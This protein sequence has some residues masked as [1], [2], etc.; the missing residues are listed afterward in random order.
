[1]DYFYAVCKLLAGLGGFL[2]GFKLISENVEKMA[3]G[4]MRNWFNKT[5]RNKFLG[6][7][8]GMASTAMVQSSAITTVMTIGLVNAGIMSLYQ[9]TAII[10]GANIGTTI[11]AHIVA[12]Q[13]INIIDSAIAFAFIGIFMSMI[14][15]EEKVRTI[16][17]MLSGLGLVFM[18]LMFMS[19]SMS[20]FQESTTIKR[21]LTEC[22]NPFLLLLFGIVSTAIMQSSSALTS[23]IIT[24]SANNL[25]IGGGG[26]CVLYVILGS[27]IGSC[28]TALISSVGT[29]ANA[30]RVALIH[31][32]FNLIGSMI[33]MTVLL[34]WKDFMAVTFESW[35]K[36]PPMQIA[37]FHTFFNLIC[38]LMFVWFID[39]FVRIATLIIPDKKTTKKQEGL[40]TRVLKTTGVAIG[41]VIN[42]CKKMTDK[43]IDV[44]TLAFNSFIESDSTVVDEIDNKL[45]EIAFIYRD[46]TDYLIKISAENVGV[47]GEAMIS[48]LHASLSDILRIS[49]LSD[50]IV[51]YTRNEIENNLE[52][53]DTVIKE[54][55]A[56]FGKIEEL[57][58][59]CMDAFVNRNKQALEKADETENRIDEYRKTLIADHIKRLNEGKCKPQSSNVFISLVGNLERAADHLT[60]IAHA[61]DNI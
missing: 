5:S 40:D 55:K 58:L 45:H 16:G 25:I 53:S 23:I 56:M 47:K 57:H 59:E 9:A 54:L 8:I 29:N 32:L 34:L 36:K 12:L 51:K 17:M 49:E 19:Q 37:M 22:K 52:F 26:N 1:M 2:I 30:K 4:S 44:L 60:Y 42:E 14:V 41:L 33:F 43:S 48:A 50:N 27:N 15:K 20:V 10:M 7:G 46:I 13:S 35:F 21:V 24:M 39:G 6:V 11:T 18:G 3:T 38:T 31:L 61:F 28:V